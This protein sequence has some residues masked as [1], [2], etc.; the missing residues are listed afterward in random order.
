MQTQ[1]DDLGRAYKTSNPFRPWQSESVYWTTQAFDDLGRVVSV[2][3]PDSAA[4][5]TSY[6]GNAVTVTDQASKKRKSVTDALGRLIQVYEDPASLNYLT[7]YSYDTLDN[8]TK[9]VQDNNPQNPV[10]PARVFAYDSLK[11]LT[12]ATNPESGTVSYIYDNAGNLTQKTDARGVVSTYVYDVLS[13]NTSITYS[14]DPSGTLPVTHVYDAAT[15]GKGRIY[16]SQ[17]TGTSGSL[18]TTDAYDELGRPTNLREQFYVN[19]QW[20]TSYTTSRTYNLAG[21]VKTQ[22][23]PSLHSVTYNYDAAGRLA[24]DAQ[25]LAFTGSLGD[26]T[27]RTYAAGISYSSFE[28]Y[29]ENSLALLHRSTINPFTTF[30]VSFLIRD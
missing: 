7:S 4:V 17:T 10:Q 12:S 2:T 16:Q 20:S 24:D 1:Y 11:R 28:V 14:N 6:L 13:R 15:K 29:Q 25:N 23:Y 8:L 26:G 30:A 9:V 3:T 21:G 5:S 18:S 22:T 27:S 19:G